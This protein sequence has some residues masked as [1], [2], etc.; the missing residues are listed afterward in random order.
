[1][2]SILLLAF[3][4]TWVSCCMGCG[5]HLAAKAPK[6]ELVATLEAETVALVKLD[7][8]GIPQTFCAGV[9]VSPWHFVTAGH[10]IAHAGEP[11]ERAA[12][13]SISE[14]LGV[15]A[16][17]PPWDPIGQEALYTEKG[18]I[19]Y[20][21]AKVAAYSRG[22]DLGLVQ[23]DPPY[24]PHAFAHVSA[25]SIRDGDDV[26]IVGHP[27]RHM[28]S[29]ARGYVSA[30]RPDEP[31]SHGLPMPTLQ[32]AGP[33]SHGNSG[34]GA[35][36]ARGELVGIASYLESQANGMGFFVHRDAIR[37]FLQAARVL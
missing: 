5:A 24:V 1:M 10:C 4:L 18:D 16:E 28:W 25:G 12:D 13:D 37:S 32:I 14:Q 7:D 29:F 33:L 20:S 6:Q 19:A 9:W 8:D 23:V 11:L 17:N 3:S 22:W 27:Q 2:R 31:N 26:E 21:T 35:F 15:K 34:G 36:D 30:V